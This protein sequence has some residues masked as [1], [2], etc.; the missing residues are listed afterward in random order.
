MRDRHYAAGTPVSLQR[1]TV[2]DPDKWVLLEACLELVLP[3]CNK[4]EPAQ[5]KQHLVEL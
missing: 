1:Y 5:V 2:P 4:G 3:V